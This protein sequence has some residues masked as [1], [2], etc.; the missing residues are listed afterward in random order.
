MSEWPSTSV[1]ILDCSG[2]QCTIGVVG[3]F[4]TLL[5]LKIPETLNQPLP[6]SMTE[7]KVLQK[8]TKMS[9]WPLMEKGE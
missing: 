6:Q 1:C 2:P 9:L 7:V 8:K 4:V 5:A 3:I